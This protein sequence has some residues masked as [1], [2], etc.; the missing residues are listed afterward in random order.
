M[1]ELKQANTGVNPTSDPSYLPTLLSSFPLTNAQQLDGTSS[2]DEEAAA[3]YSDEEGNYTRA[4][5]PA[6]RFKASQPSKL[7][8][9]ATEQYS[10]ISDHPDRLTL[11]L[12]P[13]EVATFIGEY[14]LLVISGIVMIYGAIL[15]PSPKKYR[16]YAPTTHALPTV[17]AKGGVAEVAIIST[18]RSMDGLS[19]I[20]PLWTRLW[21]AQLPKDAQQDAV[22]PRS[23]ALVCR[24]FFLV[25]EIED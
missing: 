4:F 11:K 20:S 8:S 12:E 19:T 16:V 6:A 15:R 18:K 13:D 21:H 7:S 2:D 1:A 22:P 14:D 23:F 25:A 10:V 3:H 17:T 9:L 24:T 5:N